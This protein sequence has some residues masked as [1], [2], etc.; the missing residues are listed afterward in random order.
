MK[1]TPYN[2]LYE[3]HLLSPFTDSPQILH[4]HGR[5][6]ILCHTIP[7]CGTVSRAGVL[8]YDLLPHGHPIG[9]TRHLNRY[10]TAK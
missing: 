6:T 2:R 5:P 10:N 9:Q 8:R 7:G 3:W 1:E 4:L